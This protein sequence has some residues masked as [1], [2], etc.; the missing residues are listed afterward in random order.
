MDLPTH[1]LANARKELLRFKGIAEKS[2]QQLNEEDLHYR[3]GKED[4]SIAVIVQHMVGNMRSRFTNFLTEDGEKTWRNRESEFETTLQN[5][6]ELL[7]AWESGW[8]CVFHTLD[9]LKPHQL[10]QEVKI[11]NE[12]HLVIEAINRQLAHYAYHTGQI[13]Y[14]AKSIRGKDWESMSIPKGESERFN[15]KMFEKG[16]RD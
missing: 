14:L 13:A 2:M 15:K 9:N 6:S 1:Y 12:A 7:Q 4:N 8:D 16:S 5:K 3:P 11:R 10:M